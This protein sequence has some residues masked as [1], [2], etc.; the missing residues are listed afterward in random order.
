M[1]MTKY[2][3]VHCT[4]CLDFLFY[5]LDPFRACAGEVAVP[6]S[7]TIIDTDA[8]FNIPVHALDLLLPI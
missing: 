7:Q 1:K 2:Y 6:R 4:V 5:Y 8:L 3:Q